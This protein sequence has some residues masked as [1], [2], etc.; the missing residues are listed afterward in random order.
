V[1]NRRRRR[2]PPEAGLHES[3]RGDSMVPVEAEA[4]GLGRWDLRLRVDN[5]GRTATLS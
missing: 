2:H 4:L 3:C 5:A 1:F